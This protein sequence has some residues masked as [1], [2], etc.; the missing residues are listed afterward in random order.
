ML[1]WI[2]VA[3]LTVAAAYALLLPLFRSDAGEAREAEPAVAVFA[4]QLAEIDRE[5]ERGLLPPGEAEAARREVARRLLRASRAETALDRAPWRRRVAAVAVAALVPVVGFGVYAAIGEPDERDRPLALRAN[6]APAA[7]MTIEGMLAQVEARL[8]EAPDDGVGWGVIAPIYL[9]LGRFEEAANAFDKAIALDGASAS[10]Y[11]G[12]GESL[13]LAAGGTVS[14]RAEAAFERALAMEPEA[15]KPRVFLAIAARQR[16][17]AEEALQRWAL[18]VEG[19]TGGEP[20][21]PLARREMAA[22]GRPAPRPPP[23]P[24]AVAAGAPAGGTDAMIAAMVGR[25]STRLMESGGTADEWV[26][27]I[28]SHLVLGD[29]GSAREALTAGLADLAADPAALEALRAGAAE[30]GVDPD[31]AG[32]DATVGGAGGPQPGR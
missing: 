17:D 10:R 4:D 25:L 9:A 31:A 6:E 7:D 32:P 24:A 19:A 20:W 11:V 23:A 29:A 12:L 30:L 13:M 28:R 1:F 2:A 21:A 3:V 8:A 16:G 15:L 14:I 22:L 18:L 5:E 26:Q 27:L